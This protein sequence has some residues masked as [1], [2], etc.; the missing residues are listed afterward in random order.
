MTDYM[1]HIREKTRS[2]R[3]LERENMTAETTDKVIKMAKGDLKIFK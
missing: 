2:K 3:N 1:R